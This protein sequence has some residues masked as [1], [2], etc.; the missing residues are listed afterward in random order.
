MAF[1]TIN[2]S[3]ISSALYTGIMEYY[4]E[5]EHIFLNVFIFETPNSLLLMTLNNP[6]RSRATRND[7]RFVERIIS[8]LQS[9]ESPS[10]IRHAYAQFLSDRVNDS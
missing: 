7:V 5:N 4:L 6:E 2:L 1:V 3:N 8:S 10:H 9:H